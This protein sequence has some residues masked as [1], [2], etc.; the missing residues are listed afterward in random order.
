MNFNL[1]VAVTSDIK[2]VK[3]NSFHDPSV[4]AQTPSHDL[5]RSVYGVSSPFIVS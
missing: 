1:S 2:E 4:A 3:I 5:R